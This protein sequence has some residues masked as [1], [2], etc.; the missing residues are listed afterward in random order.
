M[1]RAAGGLWKAV[2][3]RQ[4][5]AA[6]PE[7]QVAVTTY[8]QGVRMGGRRCLLCTHEFVLPHAPPSAFVLVGP[9]QNGT[10]AIGSVVGICQEHARLPDETLVDA[11]FKSILERGLSLGFKVVPPHAVHVEGGQA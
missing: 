11:A 5:T 1:N 4:D 2:V 7:A 8:L 6:H 3:I 10:I 9:G